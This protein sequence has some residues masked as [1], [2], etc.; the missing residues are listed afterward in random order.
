LKATRFPPLVRADKPHQTARQQAETPRIVGRIPD[1]PPYQRGGVMPIPTQNTGGAKF[2]PVGASSM[3]NDDLD[4]V[5]RTILGEVG[6]NATP[7]S[8]AA[9]ASVVRNRMAAGSYGRTTSEIVH[10]P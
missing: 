9:V 5:T 1:Q 8:M 7:A 3:A 2:T 10:A 6:P 4:A